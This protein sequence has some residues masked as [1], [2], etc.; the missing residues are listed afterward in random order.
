MTQERARR[1]P[2]NLAYDALHR[3]GRI[4]PVI[5][6]RTEVRTSN[7]IAE[8]AA[9][10]HEGAQGEMALPGPSHEEERDE[11]HALEELLDA[12]DEWWKVGAGV[13]LQWE[14]QQQCPQR[15]ESGNLQQRRR[16]VSGPVGP[17]SRAGSAPRRTVTSTRVKAAAAKPGRW[18]GTKR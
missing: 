8:D 14:Q 16:M 4:P 10:L 13:T 12:T 6:S 11:L 18:R 2:P 5:L 1:Q 3:H 7:S 17:G 15:P 9:E